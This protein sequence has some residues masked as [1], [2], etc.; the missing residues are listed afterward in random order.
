MST[1]KLFIYK[2]H[3][4]YEAKFIL[5]CW[6]ETNNCIKH[7]ELP[8]QNYYYEKDPNGL[9]V[10]I[11]PFDG[12]TKVNLVFSTGN[13]NLLHN[14]HVVY[15][16]RFEEIKFMQERNLLFQF[17]YMYDDAHNTFT[18]ITY[19]KATELE[20]L[21]LSFDIEVDFK[22]RTKKLQELVVMP[23]TYE[24][25]MI[26]AK[27]WNKKYAFVNKRYF[28][29]GIELNDDEVEIHLTDEVT[30]LNEFITLVEERP[31]LTGYNI[32]D[33]D[34]MCIYF[35]SL[36]LGIDKLKDIEYNDKYNYVNILDT[37]NLDLYY[38]FKNRAIKGYVYWNAYQDLKLDTIAKFILGRGKLAVEYDIYDNQYVEYGME[39]TYLCWDLMFKQPIH[40]I[41]ILSFIFNLSTD[42]LVHRQI[43]YWMLV[44]T[45]GFMYKENYLVPTREYIR[46]RAKAIPRPYPGAYTFTPKGGTYEDVTVLDFA[47]LYPSLMFLY[48]VSFETIDCGHDVCKSNIIP[49]SGHYSC[50]MK[51]GIVVQILRA[52]YDDRMEYKTMGSKDSNNTE[53]KIIKLR[54]LGGAEI[55]LTLFEI[56]L[57]QFACKIILNGGGYGLLG[58]EDYLFF[59]VNAA[60]SI[61]LPGQYWIQSVSKNIQTNFN[62]ETLSGDTDSIFLLLHG[63]DPDEV[64]SYIGSICPLRMDVDKKFKFLQLSDKKK[65]YFGVMDDGK[66]NITG[67]QFKKTNS[68]EFFGKMLKE[69]KS[70]DFANVQNGKQFKDVLFQV[71]KKYYLMVKKKKIEK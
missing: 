21:L 71:F 7:I 47:S 44:K 53:T 42:D 41:L 18:P 23:S 58:D 19:V 1:E 33:F 15:D 27:C 52:V 37:V 32:S 29:N 61:T 14:N 12:P 16:T 67:L 3:N 65:N 36:E 25:T 28:P 30:L 43:S 51:R 13:P 62:I 48:N 68:P 57:F 8:F 50:I 4:T 70:L 20:K 54:C 5:L 24:L 63:L 35:R 26:S 11:D 55:E 22:D 66:I 17:W 38:F 45:V 64:L 6:S 10:R 31:F 40:L 2:V 59:N 9:L 34:T 60:E 56:N 49:N 69:I 39:D 46:L